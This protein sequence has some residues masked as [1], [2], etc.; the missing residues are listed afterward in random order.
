MNFGILDILLVLIFLI[1]CA[2]AVLAGL[3]RQLFSLLALYLATIAAG[4]LYP[5]AAVFVSAIGGKTPTL[6]QFIVFWI[7]F[8]GVTAA[9]E[10][11]LRKGFPDT[12]LPAL[13]FLD[14]LL[15]LLPG[16]VC[17][18]IVVGLLVATLGYAPQQTWGRALEGLRITTAYVW[19]HTALRPLL[20]QFLT[21]Y[22]GFHRLWMP[23]PP[24]IFHL[25][26]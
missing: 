25:G 12:R 14:N 23:V 7:L 18:L 5:S 19:E 15:G 4:L 6:T 17:G 20:N 11:L 21:L 13:S 10:I 16:A 22:L 2:L 9:L 1:I 3:I 8:I 26:G 24:P